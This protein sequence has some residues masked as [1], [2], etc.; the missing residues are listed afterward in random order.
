[1]G[2]QFQKCSCILCNRKRKTNDLTQKQ[3]K[4]LALQMKIMDI[5][6]D[7]VWPRNL[8]KRDLQI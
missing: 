6:M 3:P 5:D 1:M 8:W 2:Q 7:M 4:Q